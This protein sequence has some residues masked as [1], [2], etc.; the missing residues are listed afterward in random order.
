M[1]LWTGTDICNMSEDSE[2]PEHG[3]QRRIFPPLYKSSGDL[4]SDRLAFFHVLER[5]KVCF[6]HQ[7]L[8]RPTIISTYRRHRS[9]RDGSIT[10][11]DHVPPQMQFDPSLTQQH[12][13]KNY[14]SQTPRGKPPSPFSLSSPLSTQTHAS[15]HL[16]CDADALLLLLLLLLLQHIGSHVPHGRACHVRIRPITGHCKVRNP[17]LLFSTRWCVRDHVE[18]CHASALLWL[19]R[20]M[21]HDGSRARS[22]RSSRYDHK[23]MLIFYHSLLRSFFSLLAVGDI[24]PREGIPKAEKSRLEAVRLLLPS[25]LTPSLPPPPHLTLTSHLANSGSHAKLCARDVA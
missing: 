5:L 8:G 21:C 24:A 14:R 20:E 12:K 1:S 17:G 10:M 16:V 25:S 3:P 19:C 15:I 13:T 9:E 6:H 4:A 22:S 23:P 2:K 18:T 11:L 7:R